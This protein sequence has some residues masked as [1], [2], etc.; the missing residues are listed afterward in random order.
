MHLASSICTTN[1]MFT[2]DA[3][4]ITLLRA[5]AGL[6]A[7]FTDIRRRPGVGV[8]EITSR[9]L[10]DLARESRDELRDE[11]SQ[12]WQAYTGHARAQLRDGP[13]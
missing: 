6:F 8:P 1:R 13:A 3:R 10:I 2:S 4:I 11:G 5:Q 12:R 7:P 9:R